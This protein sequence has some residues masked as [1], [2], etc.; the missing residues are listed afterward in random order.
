MNETVDFYEREAARYVADTLGV[1]V[2]A[3][4]AR[5]CAR[6]PAG[7]LILDAG[8]GSGRDSRAFVAMGH[9]VHA[10][11]AS[12]AMAREAEAVLGQPVSVVRF[13]D[14]ETA[15]V[16]DGIWACASLLHV[17]EASL[18]DVLAR[19]WRALRPGGVF[20][21]SMKHGQSERRDGWGRHF[22]DATASR[23]RGWLNGLA[24]LGVIE[25]WITPDAR[26]GSSDEWLNALLTRQAGAASRL[27]AVSRANPF[28]P[29]LSAAIARADAIDFAVS[30]VKVAGMR[31]LMPDLLLALRA[32]QAPSDRDAA[33]VDADALPV[34]HGR[35][36]PARVRILTSDYLDVTDP[37]ALR[38]LMLLAACGAEVRMYQPETGGFHLKAYLFTRDA[39]QGI[40]S[41]TAFIGSSN[42]SRQ[43]L[44]EGLEWNYRVEYPGDAGFLEACECFEELFAYRCTVP[45][46]HDWI[47]AYEKR[48]RVLSG[49][50]VAVMP[51]KE[52][53]PVPTA[54]QREALVALAGARDAGY[55]RGLVVMATGLGKTWL[56]AFDAVALQARRILFVAHRE[57]IL[58]QA[59][60]AFARILPQA[61]IGFYKGQQ[62]D[63]DAD[64]LCA[65]VQTLGKDHHLERFAPRH[66]DYIVVDEFHHAA[67]V[68]YRRLLGYFEPRFLLGLT[69]TPDRT[70]QADILSLCDDNMVFTR[71][72]FAGIEAGLLAPF[73]YYGIWDDTV[74]YREIPWRNGRFDPEQLTNKLATLNRARHALQQWR[75]H[76]QSRTL[77]FCV[78]I[79]HA[80][81]M[82]QRFKA[83]GIAAAAVY[84]GSELSR[85][86]AL[87]MLSDGRLQVVFSV[88]LFNEGV[89]LPAID[90]VMMLRP[91][92]SKILFL[93]QLGRG[94]RRA[95]GKTR[96]LVLD[97][98][99][100][101]RSFIHKLQALVS[102]EARERS[103][104]EFASTWASGQLVLPAGCFMNG[105]LALL[106]F[107]KSWT[108]TGSEGAYL[109]LRESFGRRP[110]ALEYHRSGASLSRV[111]QA[112]GHWFG[113]VVAQG[114]LPD[115]PEW[116]SGVC[117][118]FLRE[119]ETTTLTKSFKLV[120]LEAFQEL[121]GWA[122]P[123]TLEALARRSR[124]IF[125]RRRGLRGDLLD[126]FLGDHL[127]GD[128][129]WQ[130][131]WSRNPVSAWVGGNQR[132]AARAFFRV[133]EG[134]FEATF[135][136]VRS[137][138]PAFETLVQ[139]LLD[140]R[141]A[142]YEG[143]KGVQSQTVSRG[144]IAP[145]EANRLAYFPNLGIAC[146]H[147]KA[148]RLDADEYRQLGTGYGVLDPARHAIA[149]AAGHSM[150][151]GDRP[152][153]DGAHLLL[154]VRPN[155]GYESL[156]GEVVVI[157]RP[158]QSGAHEYLLRQV[159]TDATGVT[160]L[161]A[162]NPAYADVPVDGLQPVARLHAVLGPLALE[163]GRA[164]VRD[165]IPGWFG[166]SFNPGN[167]NSGHIRLAAHRAHVLLV[168]LNKQGSSEDHRYHDYWV[169]AHTF[170]WQSQNTTTP[171]SL[172]GQEIIAHAR[173]GIDL[174]LF[175]RD[176]KLHQG[177]AAPFVYHGRAR[178]R[179]HTGSRPMS[180]IFDV[181]G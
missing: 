145:R 108:Q 155:L 78:S 122:R 36:A 177:K 55:R 156:N 57:E 136:P 23:L 82:A 47:D 93:Q 120:L 45:L 19:L 102:P 80:D 73:H 129:A 70:D 176:A 123:V 125:E 79:R 51:D 121:D 137:H 16:Y 152:I 28:L 99:G 106:E 131:Y 175:V 53:P 15:S 112:Y 132:S 128:A 92:E 29:Q 10:C 59:A 100:N 140:Y 38:L 179:S 90:T 89:D 62:Q 3:L 127:S 41:G 60:D 157:A 158:G 5:F 104:A 30:F 7:A 148:G 170:H 34:G 87:H 154:D 97:F 43:A 141:F 111:R 95:E 11:D 69:A 35:R 119:L 25:I 167:W 13:E 83:A 22:T 151:G 126:E 33:V 86:E 18:P 66:F 9:R 142:T 56:A 50:E 147:F 118:A 173:L 171:S 52:P 107:M 76:A 144:A 63:A 77:A 164:F 135:A 133:R 161:R 71:D 138:L 101:H 116:L 4:R 146:G 21:L 72:L 39:G 105:D 84:E 139:E 165:E 91:T 143:R 181:E 109:A 174:H 124:A 42:I 14:F 61:R 8:C 159:H 44:T 2:A 54:I 37:E 81:F 88:D 94:L 178:Y 64:V 74:D 40:A 65:S 153:R 180:V 20:Y 172:R 114:D 113:L 48:R 150:D 166:E 27:V 168:T 162:F 24:D 75:Q 96:L 103:L 149:R 1:D 85:G 98:V 68:T 117:E 163:V 160:M 58:S 67:A 169:D 32:G 110:T 49:A 31:L 6:L 26:P 130:R 12:P 46:T 17:P 134:C 115:S